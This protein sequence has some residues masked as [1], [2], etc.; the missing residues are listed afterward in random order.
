[1][2]GAAEFQIAAQT[3]GQ[4]IE[5]AFLAMDGQEIGEGLGRV[6]VPSVAGVDDGDGRGLRHAPG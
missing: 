4:V 5:A 3:D 1:M 6:I 2:D